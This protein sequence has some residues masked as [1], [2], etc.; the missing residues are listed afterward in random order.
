[1]I[2]IFSILALAAASGLCKAVQDKISHHYDVSI[3]ARWNPQFWNPTLSWKNK[4][5]DWDGGDRRRK[6]LPVSLTDAWH[7]FDNLR[8]MLLLSVAAAMAVLSPFKMV[9]IVAWTGGAALAFYAT[10]HIFYTYIFDTR[11]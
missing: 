2:Q 11:R 6:R 9:L 4:Y 7:L 5:H 10:F 1:M 3:F 8:T